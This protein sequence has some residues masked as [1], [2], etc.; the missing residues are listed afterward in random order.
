VGPKSV[1]PVLIGAA[2]LL[3]TLGAVPAW[4]CQPPSRNQ[5]VHVS[6]LADSD[7]AAMARWAKDSTCVEYVFDQ[8]LSGRRLAQSVILTVTGQDVGN[9]FE[10]LLHTM[11][12]RTTG[13]GSRR[14]V[15]AD[16]PETEQSR[17]AIQRERLDAERDRVFDHIESE[18]HKKDDT[19]FTIS[20]KGADATLA[21]MG[22]V[23][24]SLRVAAELKGNQPIGFRIVEMKPTSVLARL[25]FLSGDV[26]QSLNGQ[27]IATPGKALEAYAKLRSAKHLQARILRAGKPLTV[28]LTID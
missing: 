8:S 18:I 3:G 17:E 23:T 28:D 25:G 1:L 22:I 2:C 7:L 5:R 12:L 9:V 21:N 11:N 19:H 14:H 15:V 20:R 27:D 10:V 26:V 6:F 24:H 16:G 4:A 13:H